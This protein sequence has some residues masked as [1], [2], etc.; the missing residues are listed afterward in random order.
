MEFLTLSLV[1]VIGNG[2]VTFSSTNRQGKLVDV[3]EGP[4]REGK[5]D[6]WYIRI[7]SVEPQTAN[8]G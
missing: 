7:C 8:L 1:K 4:S 6:Y 3:D 5:Q 2:S